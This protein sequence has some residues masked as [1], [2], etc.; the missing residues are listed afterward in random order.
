MKVSGLDDVLRGIEDTKRAIS[1]ETLVRWTETIQRTAT[2]TC[3]EPVVFKGS[4]D[5]HG[6]FKLE[7]KTNSEAFDCLIDS[8][9][10]SIPS[11]HPATREIFERII[12]G[13]VSEKAKKEAAIH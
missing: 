6:K 11:M 8:I 3:G 5:E 9:R 13:L 2:E 4:I 7:A 12:Y 1:A 10:K